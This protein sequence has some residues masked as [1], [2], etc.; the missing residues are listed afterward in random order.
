MTFAEEE[1]SSG[2]TGYSW[3]SLACGPGPS[4]NYLMLHPRYW[5]VGTGMEASDDSL[6]GAAVQ[7]GLERG[8]CGPGQLCPSASGEEQV[9][10][11]WMP[12]FPSGLIPE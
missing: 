6:Q 10:N 3:R 4:Q 2:D 1:W 7:L 8:G 9:L 5:Q 11:L 12:G